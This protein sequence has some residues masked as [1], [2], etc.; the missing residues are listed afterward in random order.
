[1]KPSCRGLFEIDPDGDVILLTDSPF[2]GFTDDD[3]TDS[4]KSATSPSPVDKDDPIENSARFLVSSK[5][6]SLTSSFFKKML[7]KNWAEGQTLAQIGIVEIP[8]DDCKSE[9]LFI[10]LNIIHCKF[11]SLPEVLGLQ[12]LVDVSVATDFFQCHEAIEPFAKRWIDIC[13]PKQYRMDDPNK[14]EWIM[15]ASVFQCKTTLQT[16]T[17]FAMQTAKGPFDTKQLPI[18][19]FIKGQQ[20]YNSD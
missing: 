4:Q 9:A 5:N 6:L 17:K 16:V 15:I 19:S 20:L 1:M 2:T 11:R 14:A 12:Q 3:E 13:S 10:I 8:I 18:P 7:T